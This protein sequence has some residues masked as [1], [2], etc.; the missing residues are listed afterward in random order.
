LTTICAWCSIVLQKE[1]HL[2]LSHGICESC[3]V[4][5]RYNKISIAE[6]INKFPNPVF[7]VDKNVVIKDAN[8]MSL[9]FLNKKFS[10][11]SEKLGGEV[12][13]CKYSTEKGSCGQT[14][15]C[16]SCLIRN[17]VNKVF[18]TKQS[19]L[20]VI[21][22]QYLKLNGKHIKYK[23]TLSSFMIDEKIFVSLDEIEE[24]V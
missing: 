1:G 21:G 2:E 23:I 16:S 12:I 6:F 13:E 9:N 8:L 3:A 4:D 17:S 7:L 20:G 18:T 19:E 15:F 11:V 24:I 14:E 22:Y 5:L 10:E